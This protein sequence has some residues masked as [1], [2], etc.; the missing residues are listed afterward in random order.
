MEAER[1]QAQQNKKDFS[2]LRISRRINVLSGRKT[3][4][5]DYGFVFLDAR[6]LR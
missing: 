1:A 2:H 5:F 6:K 4:G 3:L